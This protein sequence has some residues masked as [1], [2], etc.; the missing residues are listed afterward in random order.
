M[1]HP[2]LR[3]PLS[4]QRSVQRRIAGM[5]LQSLMFSTFKK[6]EIIKLWEN[7]NFDNI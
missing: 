7:V 6:L 4:P 1:S 2:N 3:W 5:R